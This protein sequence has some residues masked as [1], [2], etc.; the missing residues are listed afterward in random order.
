MKKIISIEKLGVYNRVPNNLH[1]LVDGKQIKDI[2][3]QIS[4]KQVRLRFINGELYLQIGNTNIA[5]IE[6]KVD[7]KTRKY[8]AIVDGDC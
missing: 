7:P 8:L 4:R 2:E 3:V 5:K 6:V 1:D